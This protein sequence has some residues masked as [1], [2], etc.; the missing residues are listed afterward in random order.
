[1]YVLINEDQ[2]IRVNDIIAIIHWN[3]NESPQRD[4][5]NS[6]DQVFQ[7]PFKSLVITEQGTYPSP[8]LPQT[9]VRRMKNMQSYF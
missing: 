5:S 1:M 4:K 3:Q 2:M 8:Y 9:L 6:D 7:G